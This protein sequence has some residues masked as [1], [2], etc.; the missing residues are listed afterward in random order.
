MATEFLLKEWSKMSKKLTRT[1]LAF[2]LCIM[3]MP[4]I[5][6]HAESSGEIEPNNSPENVQNI[7]ANYETAAQASKY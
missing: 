6:V 4:G 3:I 5:V 2:M 7:Q 1:V